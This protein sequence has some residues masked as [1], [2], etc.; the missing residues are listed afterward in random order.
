MADDE[1]SDSTMFNHYHPD[2][3][4]IITF[5]II[6]MIAQVLTVIV[7]NP[8]DGQKKTRCKLDSIK[9]RWYS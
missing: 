1:K 7:I 8:D 4:S 3:V 5:I 6:P 9:Q 2:D